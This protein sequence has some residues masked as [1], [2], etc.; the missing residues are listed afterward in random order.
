MKKILLLLLVLFTSPIVVHADGED[1]SGC[2]KRIASLALFGVAGAGLQ[3]G[4]ARTGREAF[5]THLTDDSYDPASGLLTMTGDILDGNGLT[6]GVFCTGNVCL[7]PNTNKIQYVRFTR[8]NLDRNYDRDTLNAIAVDAALWI[9]NTNRPDMGRWTSVLRVEQLTSFDYRQLGLDDVVEGRRVSW[10]RVIIQNTQSG[11]TS[12]AYV[13]LDE[14]SINPL[15]AVELKPSWWDWDTNQGTSALASMAG[16]I[17]T[18]AAMPNSGLRL[19][20]FVTSMGGQDYWGT[21]QSGDIY[22][23]THAGGDALANFT[24]HFGDPNLGLI[25]SVSVHPTV[26]DIRPGGPWTED[27]LQP[28]LR[29]AALGLHKL[30]RLDAG[31][32]T[33]INDKDLKR[34][35]DT[36]EG[37]ER[38]TPW[39]VTVYDPTA[40][41]PN[42]NY[43]ITVRAELAHPLRS[44]HRVQ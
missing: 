5:V 32:L 25:D 44:I 26:N 33:Q 10:N 18:A 13:A 42:Y 40:R 2:T 14:T 39:T 4:Y 20:N 23:G 11:R 43:L 1:I 9:V 3:L 6:K 8:T 36:W 19:G 28:V 31:T 35:N 38:V 15:A 7:N 12:D 17:V 22:R 34:G 24:A 16:R 21:A 30:I 37:N 27:Q 29:N 41:D